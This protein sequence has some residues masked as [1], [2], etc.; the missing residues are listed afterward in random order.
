MKK[1]YSF[2]VRMDE[3]LVKRILAFCR[4]NN[5]NVEELGM[6]SVIRGIVAR[7]LKEKG[8]GFAEPVGNEAKI[9]NKEVG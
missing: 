2:H 5:I 3:S 1:D 7:F 4:D 6:A 9:N 8:Y